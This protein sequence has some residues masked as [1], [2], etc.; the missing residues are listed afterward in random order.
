M[1]GPSSHPFLFGIF[2]ETNTIHNHPALGVPPFKG[3]PSS[4]SHQHSDFRLAFCI[5]IF[6]NFKLLWQ[7]VETNQKTN[8]IASQSLR[9]YKSR[10]PRE[11][12]ATVRKNAT[13]IVYIQIYTNRNQKRLSALTSGGKSFLQRTAEIGESIVCID[14]LFEHCHQSTSLLKK[15][16]LHL[17]K[18]DRDPSEIHQ[19]TLLCKNTSFHT[20]KTWVH[21]RCKILG[22]GRAGTKFWKRVFLHPPRP[23]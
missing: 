7:R 13:Y 12:I 20:P 15:F 18:A 6:L 16:V 11:A 21:R 14:G 3:T 10:S 9:T 23:P 5:M 19:S 1:G 2:H 17:F 22:F 4:R 8:A